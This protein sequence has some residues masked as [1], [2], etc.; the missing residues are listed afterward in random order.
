MRYWTWGCCHNGM[1]IWCVLVGWIYFPHK[2]YVNCCS[3]KADCAGLSEKRPQTILP[4]LCVVCCSF[5]H[6][7]ESVIPS[8][9]WASLQL[10]L[11]NKVR[12]MWCCARSR[13]YEAWQLL[14]CPS[15]GQLPCR[16]LQAG[17][18][19]DEGLCSGETICRRTK[20][21][22]HASRDVCVSDPDELSA[23]CSC[24]SDSSWHHGKWEKKNS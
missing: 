5:H 20:D 22:R 15:G 3:V 6:R 19:N 8:W 16:K 13:S 1:K 23:Q 7:I 18:L 9:I 24:V 4:S 14:I 2:M 10:S 21:P 12:E 17:L 11:T